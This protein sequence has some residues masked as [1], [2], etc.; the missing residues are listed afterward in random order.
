[1][2]ETKKYKVLKPILIGIRRETGEIIELTEQDA[3]IIG[4]EYVSCIEDRYRRR[5]AEKKKDKIEC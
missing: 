1:M 2:T 5:K 3:K 4:S